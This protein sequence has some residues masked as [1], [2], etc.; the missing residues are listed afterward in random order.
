MNIT[1]LIKD[2]NNFSIIEHTNKQPKF[3]LENVFRNYRV[4][5]R[6]G[7]FNFKKSV[8]NFL[9]LGWFATS[10]FASLILVLVLLVYPKTGIRDTA[11]KYSIFSSKPFVAGVSSA[12][13]TEG[14]ARGAKIDEIFEM[15]N[16]PI[17]GMGN[18]F[19]READKNNIPYWLVA[20]VAF[21][22]SSC[23]KYTPKVEGTESSNLWGWGVWGEHIYMFEDIEEGIIV[24]SKYMNNTFYSKGITD[25]CSIMKTYTPPSDGSWCKGVKYFRDEIMDY[26]TPSEL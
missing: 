20:A 4:Y 11:V 1:S 5:Y 24:V 9:K 22:E 6:F 25:P 13:L 19:V 12:N 16:C 26:T 14:D 7:E 3:A 21:Q 2:E 23:G 10:T 15:Y 17:Q 18:V 8:K